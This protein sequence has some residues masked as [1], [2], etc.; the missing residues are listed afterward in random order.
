MTEPNER[1]S[2]Q[3]WVNTSPEVIEKIRENAVSKRMTV[4]GYIGLLLEKALE[5]ESD[6]AG[7]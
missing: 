6:E 1:I 4:S 3:V 7:T 2:T 5:A